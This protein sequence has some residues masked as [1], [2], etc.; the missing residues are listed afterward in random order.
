MGWKFNMAIMVKFAKIINYDLT[1]VKLKKAIEAL[2][3]NQIYDL[4]IIANLEDE[5]LLSI[6]GVGPRT[7]K[8]FR[9]F[10]DC[11]R[12]INGENVI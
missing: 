9:K 5:Q 7:V 2:Y 3:D 4:S 11:I 10:I 6:K 8:L 12:L 1:G